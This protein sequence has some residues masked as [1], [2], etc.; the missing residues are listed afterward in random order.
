MGGVGDL[1]QRVG[2]AIAG[3]VGGAVNA[4]FQGVS[5]VVAAGQQILPGPW[6]F[7]AV[8]GVFLLLLIWTFRK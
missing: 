3:L 2:S 5:S 1:T 4:F 7:V 8:G 6:F